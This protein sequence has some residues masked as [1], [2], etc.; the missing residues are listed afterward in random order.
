VCLIAK[1][2]QGNVLDRV[3]KTQDCKKYNRIDGGEHPTKN[4]TPHKKQK[5]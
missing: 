4:F 2:T 3:K 1:K 5:V